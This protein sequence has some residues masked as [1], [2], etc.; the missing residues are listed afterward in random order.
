[1]SVFIETSFPCGILGGVWDLIV[2]VLYHC[3][4]QFLNLS[5]WCVL[6]LSCGPFKWSRLVTVA[7][8]FNTNSEKK[9]ATD[10][11]QIKALCDKISCLCC[12]ILF[13]KTAS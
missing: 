8:P 1:M 6:N 10:L 2:K 11:T 4:F 7:L 13:S 5:L 9:N 3:S 12:Q